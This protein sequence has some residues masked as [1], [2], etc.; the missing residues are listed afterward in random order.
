MKTS[1]R[2]AA[3]GYHTTTT[4]IKKH[5]ANV[6]LNSKMRHTETQCCDR[7]T[8]GA[9]NTTDNAG[10]LPDSEV[11]SRPE[12]KVLGVGIAYPQG[13]QH[14]VIHVFKPSSTRHRLEHR[15]EWFSVS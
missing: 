8:I 13:R 6:A 3:G 2:K 7:V 11:F 5:K 15:D 12:F 14:G 4:A 10:N 9:Q 1:K